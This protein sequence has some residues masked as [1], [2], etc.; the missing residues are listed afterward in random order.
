MR[1]PVPADKVKVLSDLL[2]SVDHYGT[3]EKLYASSRAA[4]VR[5]A[6]EKLTSGLAAVSVTPEVSK[7]ALMEWQVTCGLPCLSYGLRMSC[8]SQNFNILIL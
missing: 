1:C 8:V 6:T 5:V 2:L 3:V 4:Q 7:S